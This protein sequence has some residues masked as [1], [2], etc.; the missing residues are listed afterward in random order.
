LLWSMLIL[1]AVS[2]LLCLLLTRKLIYY[3]N[4]TKTNSFL[5]GK[6]APFL[7]III[8]ATAFYLIYIAEISEIKKIEY[9]VVYVVCLTLGAVDFLIRKIPNSLILMLIANKIVFIALD[10]S[11]DE[12]KKSVFGFAVACVVFVIPS[13]LKISVG[14]GDIKLAAATGLY[15]GVIDFMQAMI[16]MAVSFALYGFY[17]LIKKTGNFRTKTAMGPYLALGLFFTLLFPIFNSQ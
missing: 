15:L 3:R 7:W 11:V 14:A 2:G 5:T 1:G 9:S 6:Y 17:M 12:I 8:G 16:I 13:F 4:K 10:F